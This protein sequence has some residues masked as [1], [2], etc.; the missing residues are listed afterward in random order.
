MNNVKFY[1]HQLCNGFPANEAN[2]QAK[3]SNSLPFTA[4]NMTTVY[5]FFLSVYFI[6][7]L[8][9]GTFAEIS[10]EEM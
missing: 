2:F 8:C 6:C 9:H 5:I 4:Q 3:R 7:V 1:P 10:E